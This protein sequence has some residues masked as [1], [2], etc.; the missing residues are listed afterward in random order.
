MAAFAAM[1]ERIV[2]QDDVH[3][4]EFNHSTSFHLDKAWI[5]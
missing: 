5:G 3:G 4:I 2:W 1:E